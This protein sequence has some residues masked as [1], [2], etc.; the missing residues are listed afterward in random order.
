MEQLQESISEV[1]VSNIFIQQ[2]EQNNT[3][4]HS[5]L[6]VPALNVHPWMLHSDHLLEQPFTASLFIIN[7]AHNPALRLYVHVHRNWV[8]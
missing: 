4:H 5:E 7:W 2:K 8:N 3:T 6:Q 1:A